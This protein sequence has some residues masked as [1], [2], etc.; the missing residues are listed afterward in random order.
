MGTPPAWNVGLLTKTEPGRRNR[1][2]ADSVVLLGA[3]VVLAL[4]A[5]IAASAEEQDQDVA[6]ALK[7]VLGWASGVWQI[8]FVSLLLLA[9]AVI[10]DVLY[11]RRWDLARDLVVALLG[12]ALGA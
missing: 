2:T 3:A 5:A 9:L 4:S 10:V 6:D 8:T 11:R 12:T 7:T 1:R